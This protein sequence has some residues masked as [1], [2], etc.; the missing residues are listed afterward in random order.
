M[1]IFWLWV[2]IFLLTLVVDFAWSMYI[3]SL[4]NNKHMRA[5]G[6]SVFISIAGGIT[7]IGYTENHWLL[8]PAVIG[9]A[10]GTYCSKYFHK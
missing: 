3:K 4:A 5:V 10:V 7:V 2:G 6:W 8:I 1:N 9:G